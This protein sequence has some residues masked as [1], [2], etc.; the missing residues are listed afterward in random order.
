MP[1][2][3]NN[4]VFHNPTTVLFGKDTHQQ[5][6]KEASNFGKRCLLV[7]GQ[8]HAVKSGLLDTVKKNLQEAN[9]EFVDHNGVQANPLLSHVQEGISSV[10]A[11]NLEF[12]I[13]LGG[14]SVID[15]AKAICAGAC[16]EHDVWKFF[17]GK[18]SIKQKLPL[19]CIST[20]AGSGS[21]M[22]GGMVL[23]N[24]ETSQKFGTGNRILHPDVSI[25][26]PTLPF[27]ASR[28]LTAYG[29]V[30]AIVHVLEFYFTT[31]LE[32]PLVQDEIIEGLVRS[33]MKN[34]E[35]ALVDLDDYQARASIMWG[36]ALALSGIPSAGLGRVGFPMH[37]IEH[38]LSALYNVNHGAGLAVVAPSWLSWRAAQDPSKIASFAH[39]VLRVNKFGY[40][41]DQAKKG[42]A[43]LRKWFMKI[44]CPV[45][46]TELGIPA[47]DIPD[48]AENCLGLAKLWR[49]DK[50]YDQPTIEE[51]L[52][53]CV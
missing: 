37:L 21:E 1:S 22:N 48:I 9:I 35:Q 32:T 27:S 7:Y 39:K 15:S 4:F 47:A 19:V 5:V 6:G 33:L 28:D 53:G 11:N 14:G 44:G 16:V 10:K 49:L 13:A 43:N 41:E 34:C 26:D 46:L 12:V 20:L 36:A 50:E 8:S 52:S 40:E 51:I 38:S 45:S 42:I 29:T 30:D 3:M 2:A 25:L 18:K 17:T 23:T 31:A 24:Q